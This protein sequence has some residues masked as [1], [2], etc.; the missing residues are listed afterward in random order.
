MIQI[1]WRAKI[2]VTLSICYIEVIDNILF[3]CYPLKTDK[4]FS[5]KVKFQ[6]ML[7]H[8]LHDNSSIITMF[9]TCPTHGGI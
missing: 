8:Q 3:I 4:T 2:Y 5:K 1:R 9:W 6:T 7:T